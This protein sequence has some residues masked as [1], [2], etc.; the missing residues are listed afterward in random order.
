MGP[1]R[2]R[3]HSQGKKCPSTVPLLPS[4]FPSVPPVT[5]PSSKPVDLGDTACLGEERMWEQHDQIQH[6]IFYS[7]LWVHSQKRCVPSSFPFPK[8]SGSL[9]AFPSYLPAPSQTGLAA[10]HFW[11]LSRVKKQKQQKRRSLE[12]CKGERKWFRSVQLRIWA[13]TETSVALGT[14]R[15]K[16]QW[17]NKGLCQGI[18]WQADVKK[19][20][21]KCL[22]GEL[23]W[24]QADRLKGLAYTTH[25][26]GSCFINTD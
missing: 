10:V 7:V 3:G 14:Q 24:Q 11:S 17:L 5:D 4:S 6:G 20:A 19:S 22:P 26:S 8:I 13:Q 2:T 25:Y 16:F 15:P 18:S 9:M 21:A 23:V 1:W 12:I